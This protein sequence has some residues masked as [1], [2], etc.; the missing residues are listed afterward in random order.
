MAKKE[1][2]APQSPVVGDRVEFKRYG[3]YRNGTV[4]QIRGRLVEIR[5][6]ATE[7]FSWRDQ[8][9]HHVC[10]WPVSATS[11]LATPSSEPGGSS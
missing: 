7:R 4:T 3:E 5:D 6:L 11:P 9:V 8:D 1:T 10:V 2:T